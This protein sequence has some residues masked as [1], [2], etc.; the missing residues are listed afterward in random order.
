MDFA[1]VLI[2]LVITGLL[3]KYVMIAIEIERSAALSDR[4]M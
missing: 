3:A 2:I 4:A 1:D